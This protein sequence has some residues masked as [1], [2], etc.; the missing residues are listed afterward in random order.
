MTGFPEVLPEEVGTP[1][2]VS[3]S[4]PIDTYT[5][6]YIVV[7]GG[8]A[9]CVLAS[10]LSEDGDVSVLLLEQGP[11]AD[12]WAS[13]VPLLSGNM[14]AKD[15][16][17]ARWWSLPLKNA[18]N[19]FLE[20]IRGEALGGTSRINGMLYTRGS[21]G[22]YNQW[23]ALG[24]D[25]WA[26]SDLERYF[27][28]S[29]KARSHPS[30]PFRGKTGMWENRQFKDIPYKTTAYVDHA[31]ELLG[32]ERVPDLNSPDAPAACTGIVDIVQDSEYH[33]HSTYRAFLHPTL[34]QDRWKHLKIC[35][36]SIVSRLE[37]ERA[38]ESLYA[39]GVYFEATNSR[40]AGYRY[41]ARA[42]EEVVLCAGA[43]GS[44]Q[45]LMM[46]GIGPQA[47]LLDK[48]IP[49]HQDMPAVGGHLSDHMG[50]PVAFEVPLSDSLHHL[51]ES[52]LKAV[53][54]LA[55][56][57]LSGQGAFSRPFQNS[58]TFVPSR[59][60]DDSGSIAN[61]DP[62]R[63]DASLPENRPDI[64]LMHIAHDCGDYDVSGK[65]VYTMLVT[66]I[67]P[68]SEGSVRLATSNP[69]A[70]PD[71]DLGFLSDPSDYAPLRKGIR[72]ALRISEEV[73]KQGYPLMDLKVPDGTSDEDIN[74][75]IREHLRTCFHYT[76]TCRMGKETH[77]ERPSVVDTELKVHG[78]RG[79]RVC[80]T[81]VFPEI[82][83]SHIMAPAVMVAEKC[84]DTMK[85][86]TTSA[87]RAG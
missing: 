85:G 11:V 29:E 28:K 40:K 75:F 84:A 66:L 71:V 76:S 16:L 43:L 6:D 60:L 3:P 52:P 67:R 46:S 53:M 21:P 2:P 36:N 48:G 18:D 73:R 54:E 27:V 5:Y 32:I 80:D 45:I 23:K 69:R 79:L 30:A 34:A 12:T 86:V 7:G 83:G 20:I 31:V 35:P 41:L 22:D 47:H 81:S 25:G 8:T 61:K 87:E 58:S 62:R 15:S 10:R 26:Y 74:R 4:I 50:V 65:G 51:E 55:R 82:I 57:I 9:G 70:R 78:V 33:R 42:R 38:G 49:V 17:A 72:L 77:G 68:K 59:L 13:R 1:I 39:T 64:E 63:L 37:L 24:H 19:R 56:Y 14:F 44:P